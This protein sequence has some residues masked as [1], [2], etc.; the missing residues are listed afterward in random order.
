MILYPHESE[1]IFYWGGVGVAQDKHSPGAEYPVD[2]GEKGERMGEMLDDIKGGN[3]IELPFF[4]RRF[5]PRL[6]EDIKPPSGLP[7][8]RPGPRCLQTLDLP[9]PG[10]HQ[11]EE[12]TVSGPHIQKPSSG[13]VALYKI[14]PFLEDRLHHSTPR[15][16][17]GFASREIRLVTREPFRII[18]AGVLIDKA[19][20]ETA[21]HGIR[22][23]LMPLPCCLCLTQR[24]DNP[25]RPY[26]LLI[27]HGGSHVSNADIMLPVICKTRGTF[28]LTPPSFFLPVLA[29]YF[30]FL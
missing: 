17:F 25:F 13:H 5:F 24:A 2:L 30:L 10:L 15:L 27:S 19:A 18:R 1:N 22:P 28:A 14:G 6:R 26:F 11:G 20:P 21:D 4:E 12:E 29:C 23:F 8:V 9:A 7:I 16:D 3:H